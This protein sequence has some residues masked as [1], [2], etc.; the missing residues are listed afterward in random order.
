MPSERRNLWA[1]AGLVLISTLTALAGAE[2]VY[3]LSTDPP[4]GEGG[5]DDWYQRYRHMNESIY[6]R[7]P[8]EG[9]VYEPRPS[10]SVE[11]EYGVAGF[12]A[13]GR[14]S[15][16]RTLDGAEARTHIVLLGD[17]LVWS[18]YVA[19]ADSLPHQTEDALGPDQFRV[20]NFGVSGYDTHEERLYYEA[21]VR[22][23]A[24]DVV[25]VVFCMNDLFIA[26]GPYGRFA[27]DEERA[28]KD[29]QD[30]M[31]DRVARVRRE[32]LDGVAQ[33]EESEATFK[34]WARLASIYRRWAFEAHYVDEYTIAAAD[35]AR[36]QRMGASLQ[37]LG[38][39]IRAEGARAIL[40]ISP[41]LERWNDYPWDAMHV[42]VRAAGE[43]AGFAV[44]DPLPA[45]RGHHSPESLRS[46]GDNLH[47]SAAGNA[48][49]GRFIAEVIRR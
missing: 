11:M 36:L 22:R 1:R 4:P 32:T 33:T 2:G 39:A 6:M 27:T 45:W 46:P 8:V 3:R 14:R 20:S 10:S 30:A 43:A 48:V 23:H 31:F 41:M 25:V 38:A 40:V 28:Q 35:D 13:E 12:D 49:F 34:L 16:G 15:D 5:D 19:V 47:Y 29:A 44:A 18:E 24:A 7:S 9:L 21:R 26:S 17:S 42:A 37:R